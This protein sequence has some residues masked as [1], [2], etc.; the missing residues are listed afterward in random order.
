MLKN[1]FKEKSKPN[2]W[3]SFKQQV[4]VEI[5]DKQLNFVIL[6][7]KGSQQISPLRQV[8]A[9]VSAT[10]QIGI[11]NRD[12]KVDSGEATEKPTLFNLNSNGVL[13]GDTLIREGVFLSEFE[14]SL[15][16]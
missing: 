14:V 2:N 12:S 7:K 8:S 15:I 6:A 10:R 11:G 13:T 9:I 5:S 3:A 4:W 1:F 16:H